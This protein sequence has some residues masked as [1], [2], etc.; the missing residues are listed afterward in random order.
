MNRLVLFFIVFPQSCLGFT[1]TQV[2]VAPAGL[3]W[4]LMLGLL[5]V[6][7]LVSGLIYLWLLNRR[8]LNS[9]HK[10]SVLWHHIPDVLTE[11]DADGVIC[12]VNQPLLEGF[13][14]EDVVGT[15]SYD[16]LSEDDCA[17]FR[18]SLKRA[19]TQGVEVEYELEAILG[20][21]KRYLSN[22][23]MPLNSDDN[24]PKALVITS[25]ISRHKEAS[26]ILHQAKKQ[27]EETAQSKVNFLARMSHEI[28]TPLGG[29]VG[30]ADLLSEYEEGG[31]DIKQYTEPLVNSANH[32]QQIVDDV[33]DLAKTDGGQIQ[34]DETDISLWH[35]LDDLEALYS[36]Q[37]I[38]KHISISVEFTEDVPRFIRTDAFRLRQVLYNLFSNA[39]KFTENGSISLAISRQN[40]VGNEVLKFSVK[41]TGIGIA[42]DNQSVIFDAFSQASGKVAQGYGGTG[43]GL[44]ICRNLVEIMGGV[45]GVES[46]LNEGAEFWFTLPLLLAGKTEA[47]NL[48]HLSVSL[49]VK[50]EDK[51]AWFKGFLQGSGIR[52][53][54]NSGQEESSQSD[55]LI[56]DYVL[57]AG[58]QHL[59]WL[60]LDYELPDAHG[61]LLQ[62][63]YRREALLNRMAGYIPNQS[64][65]S[66]NLDY[67][68]KM[69]ENSN[70]TIHPSGI[71]GGSDTMNMACNL[72]VV[73][74]N[75]TNQMVIKKTLEKMGYHVSVANNGE[76]GV[77]SFLNDTF[78]GVIM[79]VQ[80][81]VMDGIE[82]TRKIRQVEGRYVPI[83]ALTANAQESI[84]E[85][86]FAAGMDA[87]L[88]KPINRVELQSTLETVLGTETYHK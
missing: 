15:S 2:S 5:L 80:M 68:E 28:R 64:T 32:L 73:E 67:A 72:L 34:L 69:N 84:E 16:Y 39:I 41:D 10:L 24:E 1:Q 56:T 33:L 12:A 45:M 81:P 51:E 78:Q 47:V 37:A 38:E 65:E 54:N 22:R 42:K 77:S 30:M 7:V 83:I 60:G 57:D 8:L 87:F 52:F 17:V 6:L 48:S 27:A 88:T 46:E 74:D 66:G 49:A 43:L 76:E 29:I 23:I 79:D 75:L 21:E 61:I 55:L 70:K 82:A 85:A 20:K 25:D 40:V 44:S 58:S 11:V 9:K 53:Q 50:N 18:D 3:P 63:P 36:P 59:W 35:V 62:P 71:E 14:I 26:K 31:E 19:L 13:S 86:C 4:E